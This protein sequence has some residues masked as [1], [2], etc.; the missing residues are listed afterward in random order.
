[1]TRIVLAIYDS[2][3]RYPLAGWLTFIVVSCCIVW[4]FLRL[5]YKEDITD[6][7]P[8]DEKNQT[9]LSVYQD[10]SGANKIYAIVS[11]KD[12]LALSPEELTA[13]V[14]AFVENVE[15]NDSLHYLSNIVKTVDIEKFLEVADMAY[16]NVP[17]FIT[18]EDYVRIDSLLSI[19][20][21]IDSKLEEDM[22][23]LLFPSSNLLV[24]N[25]ARDPLDLFSPVPAR[26][27]Q[28]GMSIEF[29]TY[30]GY[31]LSPD[32]TRAII[33]LE[34]AS[35]AHE[36]DNNGKLAEILHNSRQET[37]KENP[38]LDIHI[39]GG[40]VI[41]VSNANRIKNDSIL[42]I[43]ISGVLI[44]A[45]LIYVFRSIRNILLIVVSI[46]W[47]WL[48]AMAAIALYYD[49][50]SIIVIGITSVMLGIAVNYPLHLI[51]HIK[52]SSNPR[53]ALA[54]IVSPLIVGNITT[55]GAFLCLVPLN[56]PALHDLG[57]FSSLLLIGTILFV[58]V[59]LPHAVRIRKKAGSG[60]Q[61]PYMLARITSVKPEESKVIVWVVLILTLVFGAFSFK[62]EFDSDIR[63][64]NYMTDSQKE[65]MAYFHSLTNQSNDTEELYVVSFG[66]TW[67][68]AIENN[69]LV[70]PVI[71]SLVADG[72]LVR[73]DHL[74]S[75]LVSQEQQ[76]EKLIKWNEFKERY[77]TVLGEQLNREAVAKGFSPN[78][79]EPFQTIMD[80]HYD[81]KEFEEYDELI[82][83]V[84]PGS[85]STD[86][87]S[88]K[89]TIVQTLTVP[90]VNVDRA[91]ETIDS[92]RE[93]GGLAFDV[94]SMNGSIANSL[95]DDFNYIGFVCGG[96]VFFFLWLSLGR[97]ELAIIS[98][99]PMAVSWIWILGIM[100]MLGIQFNIVN[101]IL[102][103]FIFGQG[104][105]YTIFITEG[106]SYEL[107]YRKKVLDSYK[108]SI[109]VSAL[110]MFIGIGTLLFAQHPALR[111]LGQVT[112]VGMLSVVLMAYLFPPLIFKWLVW[113]NGRLRYQPVTLVSLFKSIFIRKK[114]VE[115]PSNLVEATRL[116]YGR[117]IYKGFDIERKALKRL[118]E[119]RRNSDSLEKEYSG[120]EEVTIVDNTGQG[121][122]IVCLALLF[123]KMRIYAWLESESERE[124]LKGCLTDL[125]NNVIVLEEWNTVHQLSE[126]KYD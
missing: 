18:D 70:D 87:N 55:V 3:R 84:F 45:L 123:P 32:G 33:I 116:A 28:G 112:V 7:L 86:N 69:E 47:G 61:A 16:E 107:A 59:F 71:D 113:K 34:S 90:T 25:I 11:S 64:I 30:D 96:V 12:S 31:I 74:S 29:D 77:N 101:I 121:E 22:Q 58:L 122:L 48:F 95:S 2:M 118:K 92:N 49:S 39:I 17:Y 43:V 53:S 68:E 72:K 10:I 94:K 57:L 36:S 82:K 117:Y 6:F 104:D 1:M 89:N 13:G 24:S 41:A 124:I 50:I 98:F 38:N 4:L 54:E 78:A 5:S 37:E 125:Q 67:E 120:R 23:A 44:L 63:H 91:R 73:R 114:S 105:D 108:N 42:A 46:G 97:I 27:N 93:F 102:A 26:L 8:L 35:G 9:A 88:G 103:T 65:D 40:P 66:D 81:V 76:K 20:G 75:F 111:S 109:V 85:M 119:I 80:S 62:T 15:N 19:P 21:Y 126:N 56:S 99:M 14:D 79:F 100:G 52:D 60:Y 51:D 110:I 83:T 115:E 106:L